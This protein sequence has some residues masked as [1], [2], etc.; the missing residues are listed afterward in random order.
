MRSCVR[1]RC[2]AKG[3]EQAS[4]TSSIRLC[5]EQ[6]TTDSN[7]RQ[8]TVSVFWKDGRGGEAVL[9]MVLVAEDFLARQ[10]NHA[11]S[12]GTNAHDARGADGFNDEVCFESDLDPTASQWNFARCL[13]D[14]E[15]QA[16]G[17]DM[18]GSVSTG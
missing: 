13:G 17:R 11:P 8:K 9:G 7:E 15:E 18:G 5:F 2:W 10:L 6:G 3:T 4:P 1:V 14:L 12:G 16:F